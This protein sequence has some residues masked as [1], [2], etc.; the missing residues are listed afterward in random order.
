MNEPELCFTWR[1]HVQTFDGRYFYF[2]GRCT[3]KLI[4]DCQ[5]DLFSVHVFTDP[6]CNDPKNCR[7]SVNL[8]LGGLDIKVVLFLVNESEHLLSVCRGL[9]GVMITVAL[10][11]G[12][13]VQRLS[14]PILSYL[15]VKSIRLPLVAR[16]RCLFWGARDQTKTPE[17][18]ASYA[19]NNF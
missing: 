2:P 8:Y 1:S 7:R 17:I 11:R 9:W 3:Y 12:G 4:H 16:S 15:L 5:D 18:Q 14:R 13:T 10:S 6:L 19:E